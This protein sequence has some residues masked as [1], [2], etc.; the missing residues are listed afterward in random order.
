VGINR[1]LVPKFKEPYV[2]KKVLDHDRYVVA[3]VDGFQLMQRPYSGVGAPDQMR[4][5]V[6][7]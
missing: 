1:K 4:P 7:L 6:K 3:D 5:Y 2:V